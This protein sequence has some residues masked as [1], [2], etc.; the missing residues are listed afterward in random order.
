MRT[1]STK[2]LRDQKRVAWT[3]LLLIALSVLT[4]PACAADATDA[5]TV[6]ANVAW[7]NVQAIEPAPDGDGFRLS[8]VPGPVRE[9][10][11]PAARLRSYSTAGVEMRFN[12]IGAEARVYLKYVE[13]RAE[14]T[15]GRPLLVEVRQGDF[16][17]KTVALREEWTEIVITKPNNLQTLITAAKQSSSRFDAALVRVVL[18]HG[19]EVRVLKVEGEVGPPRAAQLPARR[20]LAYGSSITHGYDSSVPSDPYPARMGRALGVESINLGFGSG[21]FLEPEMAD[22]IAQ[23]QDWDFASLELGVNLLGRLKPDEFRQRVRYFLKTLAA[24][25]PDKWIFVIDVFSSFRDLDGN[26]RQREYRE[27]VQSEVRAL[28]APKVVYVNGQSLLPNVAGLTT[29]LLH[30]SADGFQE[31]TRNLAARVRSAML[32]LPADGASAKSP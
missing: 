10:L 6:F 16:L 3:G 27:V 13:D 18:P 23:R 29:D 4:R 14:R 8:R 15:K 17:V 9:K 12:L 19:T 20:Y 28:G 25:H 2:A 5:S 21:A 24:A 7:N 26:T 32:G 30:P 22:W 31:I 1:K 11:N